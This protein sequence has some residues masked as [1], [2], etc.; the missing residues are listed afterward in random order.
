M[1]EDGWYHEQFVPEPLSG[2]G[3]F[4]V[5]HDIFWWYLNEYY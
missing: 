4:F 2:S 5:P 3:T 1:H